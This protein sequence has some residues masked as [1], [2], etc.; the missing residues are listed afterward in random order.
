MEASK[1]FKEVIE[2]IERLKLNYFIQKTP[3]SAQ[4]FIKR[5]LIKFYDTPPSPSN[6]MQPDVKLESCDVTEK[7]KLTKSLEAANKKVNKL[8]EALSRERNKVKSQDDELG[9]LRDDNIKFKKE[10]KDL[11]LK[12]DK[13]QNEIKTSDDE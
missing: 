5:S 4:I 3:F 9:N 1:V 12:L 10:K 8:E 2:Y 11:K 13:Q 7:V 6:E